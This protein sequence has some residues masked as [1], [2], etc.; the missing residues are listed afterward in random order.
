MEPI[1][2]GISAGLTAIGGLVNAGAQNAAA[3][4]EAEFQAK[5]W[6]Y[7]KKRLM[8]DFRHQKK[9]WRMNIDN[10]ESLAS[11]RDT[12]N[13]DDWKYK[14]AIN[15]A[16]YKSQM[17][18]FRKSE[19][20]FNQQLSFN[21][22]ASDAANEAEYRKLQD[23]TNEIAFQ[24]QDIIVKAMASEGISA[25]KGQSGRSAGKGEQ[26]NLAALGR[27]Q[28][29]LAESLLSAKA[30]TDAA[31]RKVA[32]DKYGADIAA[33]AQRMLEPSRNPEPPKPIPTPRTKYLKPRRP[34]Y[35]DF[36]PKP[37]GSTGG[38]MNIAS[39][40]IGGLSSIV[41]SL[42]T[43]GGGSGSGLGNFNS[44]AFQPGLNLLNKS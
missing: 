33:Y 22:L 13:L 26:A 34:K 43:G 21:R 11:Y 29:I 38:G 17:R 30:D 3:R 27:N 23:A 18:M 42:P 6:E 16:E 2:M 4:R 31:L 20:I 9:Q 28:S 10:E 41:G 44:L 8:A 25:V 5:S 12:T 1:T 40:A 32:A 7:G 24:N 35:Y 39:A 14:V 19:D 15:D 36:G 37:S